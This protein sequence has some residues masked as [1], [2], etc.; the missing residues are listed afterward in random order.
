MPATYLV[1]LVL[2]GVMLLAGYTD[3]VHPIQL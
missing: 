3:I 2:G 1:V